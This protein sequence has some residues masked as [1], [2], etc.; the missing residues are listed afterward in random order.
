MYLP[1]ER[2]LC[3]ERRDDPVDPSRRSLFMNQT[4][5]LVLLVTDLIARSGAFAAV[6]TSSMRPQKETYE[7]LF[8]NTS[9]PIVIDKRLRQIDNGP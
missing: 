7:I 4:R 2:G 5:G 3:L 9:I 6:Y 1:L 8:S